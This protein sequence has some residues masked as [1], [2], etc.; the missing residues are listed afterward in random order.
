MNQPKKRLYS[1]K[2]P[3]VNVTESICEDIVHGTKITIY[4][5]NNDRR[6]KFTHAIVKDYILWFTKMGSVERV[7]GK[8][9]NKDVQLFLKGIDKD[10][11][12]SIKFG[13]IFPEKK[14]FR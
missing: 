11:F 1:K 3:E 6:D 8:D 10:E 9:E 4:G 5:Y 14:V 12:E 2:I 13:H 7:F